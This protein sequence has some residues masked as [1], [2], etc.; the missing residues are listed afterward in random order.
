M[1]KKGTLAILI[2]P[3]GSGKGTLIKQLLQQENGIFLSISA[4]TR[5][6]RPGEVDG[7]SYYFTPKADFERMIAED[8]FLEYACYCDN[9]YGTPKAPV[10]ERLERG[11]HVLLEIEMQ[12]AM[13]VKKAYPDAVS[14]FI[15]PPSVEE[16][17]K[18][19]TGRGTETP[20]VIEKRMNAA[21]SEMEYARQCDRVVTNDEVERAAKEIA[22]ILEHYTNA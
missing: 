16:L 12:G 9:Y 1:S 5:A 17:R 14:I 18:R 22:D 13:Q 6:P 20:E 3:S 21:I 19:L 2:G 15:M 4:T 8:A 11:E 7:I 10:F